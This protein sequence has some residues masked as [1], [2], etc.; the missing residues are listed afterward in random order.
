MFKSLQVKLLIVVSFSLL[1]VESL[2]IPCSAQLGGG[3]VAEDLTRLGKPITQRW[4]I[5]VLI[6]AGERGA[7]SV[8]LLI[9]VPADWDEQSVAL[10]GEDVSDSVRNLKYV[11]LDDGVRCLTASIPRIGGGGAVKVLQTFDVQVYPIKKPS[12]PEKLM[13][14]KKL[15]RQIKPFLNASPLIDHRRSA[16]KKL[17]AELVEN[18]PNAWSQ[19]EAFHDWI[20]ANIATTGDEECI[21]TTATLR[22]NAGNDEDK[23]N[24]FVAM[25][26]SH[27]VPARIVWAEQT[28]YAEFYLV[29]EN[30]RGAW[31]PSQPGANPEFGQISNPSVVQ[32]KGDNFKL[33]NGEKRRFVPELVNGDMRG[34]EPEIIFVRRIVPH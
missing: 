27:K 12:E 13:V 8:N 18:K 2:L 10:V 14:P 4:Q 26:R 21:G 33:P 34:S 15:D 9:P 24:L 29:D 25:C 11:T 31:Y 16:I 7:S 17:V 20:V 32:Q 6:Q 5:G 28:E 1:C 3:M 22:N 19:I 23:I 30:E